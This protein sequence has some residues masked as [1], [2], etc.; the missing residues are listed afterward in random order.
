MDRRDGKVVE[1]G[2]FDLAEYVDE[3]ARAPH[4]HDIGTTLWFE[5][6]HVRVFELRLEP[7]ER[8]PFHIHDRTYFWTVIE[9]GRGMQRRHDGTYVVRDYRLGETSYLVHAPTD[10]MI[11]DLANI[12]DGTLRFVTVELKH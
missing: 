7:G 6:E 12:G 9:P 2:T 1:E 8:A 5:N 3:L 11:H 4:N 10:R